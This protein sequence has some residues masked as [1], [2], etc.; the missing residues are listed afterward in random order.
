MFCVTFD[1]VADKSVRRGTM[2]VVLQRAGCLC[3]D[4][5]ASSTVQPCVCSRCSVELH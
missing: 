4:R 1:A 2:R 3:P 5:V